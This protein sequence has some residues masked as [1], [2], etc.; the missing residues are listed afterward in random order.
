V[1]NEAIAAGADVRQLTREFIE[2]AAAAMMEG[3]T[4]AAPGSQVEHI[5]VDL[6]EGAADAVIRELE[7]EAWRGE[8]CY[9]HYRRDVKLTT[10]RMLNGPVETLPEPAS[11]EATL[12]AWWAWGSSY[13]REE[14]D[15]LGRRWLRFLPVPN[16]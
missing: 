14:R 3:K 7:G 9:L 10:V 16:M 5:V 11:V 13:V 8:K 1:R 6:V 4:V 12:A 15:D 2:S